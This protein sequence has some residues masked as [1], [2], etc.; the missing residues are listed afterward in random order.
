MSLV[1]NICFVAL[2]V[3]IACGLV[4]LKLGPSLLDR[5]LAFDLIAT[6]VVAMVVLISVKNQ[7]PMYLEA[8]LIVSLL[9]F[10]TTVAFV[11]YFFGDRDRPRKMPGKK[12]D[13]A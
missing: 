2:F 9:G 7:T 5:V 11:Y 12:E 6:C 13:T 3:V 1:I 8:I 10:F 4:R